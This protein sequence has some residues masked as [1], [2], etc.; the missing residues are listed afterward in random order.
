MHNN[1][2]NNGGDNDGSNNAGRM[3]HANQDQ[4][5]YY[6]HEHQH[7]G[8]YGQYFNQ[9]PRQQGQQQQGY[10]AMLYHSGFGGKQAQAR[11]GMYGAAPA[12]AA[13][14]SA[15]AHTAAA[16]SVAGSSNSGW[17]QQQDQLSAEDI[18]ELRR[19]E[20]QWEDE[21]DAKRRIEAQ[22]EREIRQR[23]F[24]QQEGEVEGEDDEG[25]VNDDLTDKDDDGD[26]GA[27]VVRGKSAFSE[28]MDVV[29]MRVM[30]NEENN[31]K[32]RKASSVKGKSVSKDFVIFF[33]F[34]NFR[35][36]FYF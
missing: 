3:P 31:P 19:L 28:G 20:Q 7:N 4:S 6:Y 17:Q 1:Q 24:R 8:Q 32:S 27:I 21:R 25:D 14:M 26:T 34:L 29:F 22:R 33:E 35:Q 36:F 10:A 15:T 16:M 5:Q 11:A 30:S 2:G 9:Q 12:A 23:N 18:A 13:G